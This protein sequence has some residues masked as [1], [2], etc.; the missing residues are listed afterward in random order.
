MNVTKPVKVITVYDRIQA[1]M[2]LDL[3]KQNGIPAYRLGSGLGDIMDITTG[4]SGMAE[5]IMVDVRC[6]QDAKKL[7][8]EFIQEDNEEIIEKKMSRRRV[9]A[10]IIFLIYF[11]MCITIVLAKAL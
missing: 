4:N 10:L 3:L 8:A 9:C 6:L 1:E 7:L 11:I 2:I 5:D